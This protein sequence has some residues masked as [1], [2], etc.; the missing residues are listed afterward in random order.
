MQISD[1]AIEVLKG[2]HKALAALSYKFDK[3]AKT[4]ENWLNNK[5]IRLTTPIAIDIIK[6]ETGLSD[7]EIFETANA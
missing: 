6:A 3:H 5:D 1:K 4:I 2:N 7:S